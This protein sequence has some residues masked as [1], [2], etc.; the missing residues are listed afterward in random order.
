MKKNVGPFGA[1]ALEHLDGGVV[2][3]AVRL[4]LARAH[5]VHVEEVLHAGRG[6]EAS[7]YP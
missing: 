7:A 2:V 5:R 1:L 3:E 6:L 4:D